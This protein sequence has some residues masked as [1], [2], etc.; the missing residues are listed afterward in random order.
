MQVAVSSHLKSSFIERQDNAMRS[1][2][3]YSSQSGNTQKLAE[4][5]YEALQGEKEIYPVE[6]APDSLADFDFI[7][8]GFWLQGGNPD[9]KTTAFLPRLRD[10]NIF[11]FATHGAAKGSAHARRGMDQAIASAAGAKVVGTF[12]CQG[13]VSPKVLEAAAAKPEP[14]PWLPDAPAA[15]GHPDQNDINELR[16]LL[17]GIVFP[18]E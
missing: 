16:R 11:L 18:E 10:R 12:S 14:P 9:P 1:L 4:V 15:K 13:E 7:A 6:E 2:I 3:L 17:A 5:V 8:V